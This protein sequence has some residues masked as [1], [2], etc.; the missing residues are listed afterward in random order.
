MKCATVQEWMPHYIDGQLSPDME[1][2]L[3]L[4]TDSCP[5]CAQWLEEA[6]ELAA[7]WNEEDS[8]WAAPGLPD[9]P[10]LTDSVM[11][12]IER[13]ENG[14]KERSIQPTAARRRTAPRTS[15]MHYCL[16]VGLT[17]VLVQLGIFENLA[18]GISEINGHMSSSVGAWL[19]NTPADK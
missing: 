6:R 16:A 3:R 14:R 2:Q 13:L 15:W 1:L 11:S 7:I 12:E 17:L 5:E 8:A 19:S 4:H 9:F 10:D 18:Y